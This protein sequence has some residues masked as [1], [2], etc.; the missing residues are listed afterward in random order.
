M[1]LTDD[2]KKL[3]KDSEQEMKEWVDIMLQLSLFIVM[4]LTS[5]ADVIARTQN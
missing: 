3:L 4:L 5:T 1:A 2:V